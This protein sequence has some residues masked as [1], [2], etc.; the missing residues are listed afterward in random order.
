MKSS[1]L[2][3]YTLLGA[4]SALPGSVP[5]ITAAP[6]PNAVSTGASANNS[7]AACTST[8]CWASYAECNGSLTFVY[9]CYTPPPCGTVTSPDPYSCPPPTAYP[10]APVNSTTLTTFT[11][12]TSSGAPTGS[13]AEEE[14]SVITIFP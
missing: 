14:D 12:S 4:V 1:T 10:T 8:D 9:L 3:T 6:E 13:S 11:T 7:S 5:T 2:V